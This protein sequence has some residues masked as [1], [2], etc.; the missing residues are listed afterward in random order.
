MDVTLFGLSAPIKE[1]FTRKNIVLK[2]ISFVM[3]FVVLDT[4][5]TYYGIS[6]NWVPV[7]VETNIIHNLFGMDAFLFAKF[8][9]GIPAIYLFYRHLKNNTKYY[10][11]ILLAFTSV[12]WLVVISNILFVLEM[13]YIMLPVA[14]LGLW[15]HALWW[16]GLSPN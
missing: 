3:A 12:S 2:I 6:L 8:A 4:L 16:A 15:L 10:N 5:I 9:I 1:P 14:S 7:Y 13:Q 11:G